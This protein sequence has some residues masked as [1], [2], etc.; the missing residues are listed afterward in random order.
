MEL[1]SRVCD[2]VD[3]LYPDEGACFEVAFGVCARTVRVVVRLDGTIRRVC[4]MTGAF[5]GAGRWDRGVGVLVS[6]LADGAGR[7]LSSS[8]DY[9]RHDR[10]WRERVDIKRSLQSTRVREGTQG[11]N[12][13]LARRLKSVRSTRVS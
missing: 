12:Y 10:D 7:S 8:L 2:E 5:A 11:G 4:G 13:S 6:V 9:S 3:E 1:G